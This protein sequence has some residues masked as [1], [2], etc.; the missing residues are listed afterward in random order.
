[1]KTV[2]SSCHFVKKYHRINSAL[3]GQSENGIRNRTLV[4]FYLIETHNDGAS[5]ENLQ[6][7]Q[8]EIENMLFVILLNH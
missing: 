5:N 4:D 8:K 2:S 3:H 7:F 6:H 1:M